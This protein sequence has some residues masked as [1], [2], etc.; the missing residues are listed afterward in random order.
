MANEYVKVINDLIVACK[1]LIYVYEPF[2][3]FTADEPGENAGVD[4]CR[5]ASESAEAIIAKYETGE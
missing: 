3:D 1:Q 5:K 2:V 4:A